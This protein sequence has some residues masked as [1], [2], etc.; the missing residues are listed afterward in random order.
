MELPA[1]PTVTMS[2]HLTAKLAGL[3]TT[4]NGLPDTRISN[5]FSWG[6]GYM[7]GIYIAGGVSG[8]HPNPAI[9]IVLSIFRGF[10]A[11]QCGYYIIAQMLGAIT[12][13]GIA[14]CL[15][16]NSILQMGPNTNLGATE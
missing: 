15:Y 2:S 9:S 4:N 11:R 8:A 1:L 5:N 14:Y 10:P 12:A 16:R 6:L 7:G 13:G 3:T